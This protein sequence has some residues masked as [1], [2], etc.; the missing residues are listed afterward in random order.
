MPLYPFERALAAAR[1]IIPPF[2]RAAAAP[3]S[4]APP[5]CSRFWTYVPRYPADSHLGHRTPRHF[6]AADPPDTPKASGREIRSSSVLHEYRCP[7]NEKAASIWLHF[8][9]FSYILPIA[10]AHPF[11][12]PGSRPVCTAENP[13]NVSKIRHKAKSL[14]L[15]AALRAPPLFCR[16]ADTR[17]H[18][19]ENMENPPQIVS[20]LKINSIN[21][22]RNFIIIHHTYKAAAHRRHF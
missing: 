9:R 1:S 12:A 2:S 7:A 21:F 15:G 6:R 4:T 19:A 22:F 18:G 3:P 5:D 11:H 8:E 16:A 17:R 13:D 14:F 10:S 20:Y